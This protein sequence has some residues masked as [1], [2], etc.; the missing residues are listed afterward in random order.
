MKQILITITLLILL[1]PLAI[2]QSLAVNATGAAANSSS[3][4]DVSSTSKGVLFPRMTKAQ[5]N[6]ITTPALGLLVF[7]AA[8]DSVGFHYYNGT[9]WIWLDPFISSAWKTTG[10]SGTDTS[11]NFIGT[12]DNMPLAFR[13]N[14]ESSGR[15]ESSIATANTYL[16]NRSGRFNTGTGNTAFGF[17]SLA[18][19]GNGINNTAI[20]AIALNAN[21]SG[22][23]NIAMGYSALLIN[24]T[25]SANIG[26]GN[27]ALQANTAGN[28]NIALGFNA[29]GAN[30]VGNLNTALGDNVLASNTTGGVNTAIGGWQ[31]MYKNI[32]GQSNVAIGGWQNMYN[33]TLGTNNVSIGGGLGFVYNLFENISGSSNI[34]I[35]GGLYGNTSGSG[36][37]ALGNGSLYENGNKNSNIAIGASSLRFNGS[38]APLAIQGINNIGIGNNAL[39]QNKR[40]SNNVAFGNY[41]ASL[42]SNQFHNVAIGNYAMGASLGD[43]NVAVGSSSLLNN[44]GNSNVAIGD[45]AMIAASQ[46]FNTA[47][48]AEALKSNTGSSNTA[49]GYRSLQKNITGSYNVAIGDSAGYN[50]NAS[51]SVAI[52]SKAMLSSTTGTNTVIGYE[53]LRDNID[54]G[55]LN[56][57]V[58][59]RAMQSA[60]LGQQNTVVGYEAMAQ[61]TVGSTQTA[62]LGNW[63]LQNRNATQT[64]AIGTYAGYKTA[65]PVNMAI[66][67]IYMGFMS[68]I[69]SLA[70]SSI[71]IGTQAGSNGTGDNNTFI[72]HQSGSNSSG[73]YNLSVGEYTGPNSGSDNVVVGRYAGYAANGSRNVY[74]G[75]YAGYAMA[76]SD[77]LA[78][79][80]TITGTPLIYGNFATNL[81]RVNGTLDINN[82]YSFPTIDGT[83]N[84]VLYTNGAGVVNWGTALFSASNGLTATSGN[85]KL[86]GTLTDSTTIVQ[87]NR[88]LVFDLNG[89]G[90]F[91]VRKNTTDDA[92]MV[93]DNGYVGIN[94]NDPLYRL[95][96][97]NVSGGNGPFGRG[98]V[99]EN[100]NTGSNGEA[101]IAFKN[102][103]PGSVATNSAWM[104][105]LNN[106]INYVFAYG[107]SLISSRVKMKIDTLGNVSI[108]NQGSLAQSKLDVN[109]STGNAIRTT[110]INQTLDVDDHTLIIGNAAPAITITLP[111]AASCDRREYVIVNRSGLAQTISSYFDFSGSSTTVAAN[112][113]ITLQ[114]N[115][116]SWFRIQ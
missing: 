59:T 88:S 20:G 62:V 99:I 68:G 37:I 30:S 54:P 91:Y 71:F 49:I 1:E 23:N 21:T 34:A 66:N 11:V 79:D 18:A 67:N 19:T 53:A 69:N 60:T 14:N 98:I 102:N 45:S 65:P 47:V 105:G 22:L 97:V 2:S 10:N 111:A 85:V 3:I 93:K 46:S 43:R 8:P 89:T 82:N 87:G 7:Q 28:E 29:L 32:S 42:D 101:S 96:V 61:A 27:Y 6:A 48:G 55:G 81:L 116:S 109:G 64:I 73:S 57:V 26:I 39:Y 78:I 113:A 50:H 107:D 112:S 103:G 86:G 31:T 63:T 75:R 51:G 104:S 13:V 110:S 108:G 76:G 15:L 92:F 52:G 38:N 40:G 56:T 35:G 24:T 16:G 94:I 17:R 25:G 90:D 84:Q 70:D 41:T 80:N 12:T 33:N 83:P 44:T 95:H 36:N 58:G 72:G 9:Q 114:S 106:G 4:L 5:K 74:I 100:T 77:L 115:G